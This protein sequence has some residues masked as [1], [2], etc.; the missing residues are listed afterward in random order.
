NKF[1]SVVKVAV[2]VAKKW[3]TLKQNKV[4]HIYFDDVVLC[5]D[6]LPK[7]LTSLTFSSKFMYP[8]TK[9]LFPD[10]LTELIFNREYNMP[11][12]PGV[13]PD[14][15]SRLVFGDRFNKPL[16][17]GVL[18]RYLKYLSFGPYSQPLEEDVLPEQ[19]VSVIF[20]Y[21]MWVR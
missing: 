3:N 13:L 10:T 15:L 11:L 17:K 18:P 5:D 8:L 6:M 19:L 7:Q 9:N 21:N 4:K 16:I 14:K 1:I 2:S 12:I 20:K